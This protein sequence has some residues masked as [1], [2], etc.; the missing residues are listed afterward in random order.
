[1]RDILQLDLTLFVERAVWSISLVSLQVQVRC[2][3]SEAS[4]VRT[5]D[6]KLSIFLALDTVVEENL[7]FT[8]T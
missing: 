8:D 3:T 6:V 7:V 4:T 5:E 2:R 1:M